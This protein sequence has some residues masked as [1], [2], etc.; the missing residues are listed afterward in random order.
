[1][2]NTNNDTTTEN[3]NLGWTPMDPKGIAIFFTSLSAIMVGL[4]VLLWGV[5]QLIG[6]LV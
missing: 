2:T 4:G 5:G 6:Q 1:M 3:N